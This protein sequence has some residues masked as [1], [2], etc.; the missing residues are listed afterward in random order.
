MSAHLIPFEFAPVT[1]RPREGTETWSHDKLPEKEW[2]TTR[3]R[4]GTE[5]FRDTG[6]HGEVIVTTRPREGT[7]TFALSIH[8]PVYHP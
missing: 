8:F 6:K 7:E 5:T 1:T 3:P 2:V 4:E